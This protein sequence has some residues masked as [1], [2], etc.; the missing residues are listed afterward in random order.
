MPNTGLRVAEK[1]EVIELTFEGR[2]VS[3]ARDQWPAAWKIG[4]LRPD[5]AAGIVRW[6]RSTADRVPAQITQV[7]IVL[8][9]V[10]SYLKIAENDDLPPPKR[11][12]A[13]D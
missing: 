1:A 10:F 3:I 7:E 12:L 2:C 13:A 6:F 5:V 9:M 4:D 11:C 8:Q